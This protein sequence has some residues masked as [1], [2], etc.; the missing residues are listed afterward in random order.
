[1]SAFDLGDRKTRIDVSRY[2]PPQYRSPAGSAKGHAVRERLSRGASHGDAMAGPPQ[3]EPIHVQGA[4]PRIPLSMTGRLAV[5]VGLIA[6]LAVVSVTFLQSK[7]DHTAAVAAAQKADV[8]PAARDLDAPKTVHTVSLRRDDADATPAADAQT[9]NAV[10]HPA[11]STNGLAGSSFD[12]LATATPAAEKTLR[13]K[14]L[15]LSAP[16]TMWA[17]FPDE[18]AAAPA[19]ADDIKDVKDAKDA[20]PHR[21]ATRTKQARRHRRHATRH[22]VR[23][24][25]TRAAAAKPQPAQPAQQQASASQP[26]KKLPIQAALDKLFGGSGSNGASASGHAAPAR[27]SAPA[28]TG[29]AF[30]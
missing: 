4:S 28:T 13:E 22:R 17:M 25:R 23:R 29:S 7:A 14:S 21:T 10:E 2:A 12:R 5:A 6:G 18:S 19:P 24:R 11:P 26:A 15:P 9:S 16:L 8:R 1:M 30:R 20:I 27:A 3:S